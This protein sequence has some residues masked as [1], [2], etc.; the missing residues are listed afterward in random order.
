MQEVSVLPK[1]SYPSSHLYVA[2]VPG[3]KFVELSVTRAF[4]GTAGCPHFTSGKKW[5]KLD[6]YKINVYES[7]L[8]DFNLNIKVFVNFLFSCA[9][10]TI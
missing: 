1:V 8:Q 4:K 9:I 5:N 2:I 7:C 10:Q 6:C 3:V